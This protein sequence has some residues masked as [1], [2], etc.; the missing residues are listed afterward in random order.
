MVYEYEWYRHD[1]ATGLKDFIEG[2]GATGPT[3]TVT[4]AEVCM[5]IVVDVIFTDDAGY[6]QRLSSFP[7]PVPPEG[8]ADCPNNPATGGPDISGT[9]QVGETL[10]AGT[11]DIWGRRRN[12][13]SGLRLPV[14]PA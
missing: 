10:T 6:R 12:D 9:A 8:Q 5:G 1:F 7:L 11:W 2:E 3:Y 13:R 4:D 14:G